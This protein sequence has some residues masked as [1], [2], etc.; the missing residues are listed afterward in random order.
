MVAGTQILG[1]SAAFPKG[2]SRELEVGQLEL[3][4]ALQNVSVSGRQLNPL[5]QDISSPHPNYMRETDSWWD[6]ILKIL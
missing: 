2:I 4:S 1:L 3:K 6:L 5:R